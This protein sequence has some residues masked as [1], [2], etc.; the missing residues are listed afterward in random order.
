ME[1]LFMILRHSITKVIYL[2]RKKKGHNAFILSDADKVKKITYYVDDTFD[3]KLDKNKVFWPA[4]TNIERG[5]SVVFNAG[6][7]VGYFNE[8]KSIPFQLLFNKPANIYGLTS[9]TENHT[10]A[11]KQTFKGDNYNELIDS[12][13]LFSQPDTASFYIGNTKVSIGVFHEKN[14]P[15]ASKIKE[16][17]SNSMESIARF[18]PNIPVENYTFLVYVADYE[19]KMKEMMSAYENADDLSIH[20]LMKLQK[21]FEIQLG[22][23]EH[24]KSSF[25]YLAD[26][27]DGLDEIIFQIK[28]T[29]I[30]EFMHIITPLSLHSEHI[31]NFDYQTP[32]MSQHLWLYEGVTEYFAKLIQLQDSS[33]KLEDYFFLTSRNIFHSSRFPESKMSFTEMSEKI[34]KKKYHKQFS[35]V[36]DRGAILA[37]LLD[38]EIIRLTD[39]RLNLKEVI[40]SLITKYGQT[41]PFNDEEF[42]TAFVNEVHPDLSGWFTKYVTGNEPLD[43]IGGFNS[44]GIEYIPT[45]EILAPRDPIIHKDVKVFLVH[46]GGDKVKKIGANEW[47]GLKPN[48]FVPYSS[49]NLA[50]KD[51]NGDFLKEGENTQLVIIRDEKEVGLPV[52]V[53][54]TKTI[55]KRTFKIIEDMSEI[56][57]MNFNRWLGIN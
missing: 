53:R 23:L 30:H 38:F 22:A 15:I 11:T 4:G 33:I 5:K 47:A 18:L 16:T 12:P 14:E 21:K 52:Q 2:N 55:I 51:S 56:Q 49:Y 46:L 42:I 44:V 34:L 48:D 27:G 7:F 6:G 45:K 43:I 39:R 36:Y 10:S 29:A 32:K 26:E 17:L 41:K 57:A 19:A 54:Y 9:L 50:F 37:M 25:Y 24:N 31:A 8:M 13:I 20:Q 28:E 40:L 1:G 3:S 35:H